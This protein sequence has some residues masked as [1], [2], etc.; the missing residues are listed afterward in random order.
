MS[1]WAERRKAIA[2]IAIETKRKSLLIHA[3]KYPVIV[4]NV[5]SPNAIQIMKI[6]PWLDETS[7]LYSA[8]TASS[9]GNSDERHV[10]KAIMLNPHANP[11]KLTKINKQEI[12]AEKHRQ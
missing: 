1:A 10:P 5:P 11:G 6:A 2:N 7:R 9:N 3:I 12:I 4:D 8:G